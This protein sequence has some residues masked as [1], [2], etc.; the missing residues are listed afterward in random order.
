MAATDKG[1][2]PQGAGS[3]HVSELMRAA[4]DRAIRESLSECARADGKR[5]NVYLEVELCLG[6]GGE[7][8]WMAGSLRF[9]PKLHHKDAARESS[10]G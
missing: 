2:V 8:L 10:N 5:G 3:L 9:R 7:P 6:D 4:A 1:P